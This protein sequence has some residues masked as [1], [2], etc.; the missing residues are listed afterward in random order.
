[1]KRY[2][3]YIFFTCCILGFALYSM[4]GGG[5]TKTVLNFGDDSLV[6]SYNEF[7]S[8]IS[9]SEI[10]TVELAEVEDFGAALEGSSNNKYRWGTWENEVWGS[11]TQCTSTLTD[12]CVVLALRDESIFVLSYQDE[13]TTI[14]LGEMIP[15]Y[16]TAHG[17]S[18]QV[19]E[20]TNA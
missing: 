6:I 8:S 5:S 12:Y 18:V 3:N 19:I 17:Y 4:F 16:L 20:N 7:E 9:Y 1:M 14:E 10:Q 2:G 15:G 13:K 11:Y